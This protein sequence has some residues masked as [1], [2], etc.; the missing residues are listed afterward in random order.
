MGQRVEAANLLHDLGAPSTA[1]K[2]SVAPSFAKG[3]REKETT[4]QERLELLLVLVKRVNAVETIEVA[5]ERG[6]EG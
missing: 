4:Y 1:S 3:Q 6:R 5:V 2:A